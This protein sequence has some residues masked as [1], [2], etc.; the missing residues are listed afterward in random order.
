[1]VRGGGYPG[2]MR[3]SATATGL[4]N[5][6]RRTEVAR[7]QM[8]EGAE[9]GIRRAGLLLLRASKKMVPIDLGPL[10]ASGYVRKIGGSG[11]K[12]LVAVGFTASYA[13]YVH[14]NLDKAHGQE[15][16]IKHA[17]D[18]A[19]KRKYWHK[20][21]GRWTGGMVTYRRRGKDQQAKFLL[22]A[23]VLNYKAM[24]AEVNESV[25]KRMQL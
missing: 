11:A 6:R 20:A 2:Q 23:I 7:R 8:E 9:I 21:E 15:Y 3:I 22:K 13:G 12:T 1:M 4:K 10:N 18:I 17:A 16:N 25:K 5:I 24:V 19:A 14:E